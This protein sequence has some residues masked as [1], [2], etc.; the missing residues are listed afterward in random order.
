MNY[1][2]NIFYVKLALG[3]TIGQGNKFWP[4]VNQNFK[5]KETIVINDN[6]LD[7]TIKPYIKVSHAFSEGLVWEHL[8]EKEF[9]YKSLRTL[10]SKVKG[11]TIK[12]KGI[13]RILNLEHQYISQEYKSKIIDEINSKV[14]DRQ[15]PRTINLSFGVEVFTYI[16][17][18]VF[19]RLD[20]KVTTEAADDPFIELVDSVRKQTLK[21]FGIE[22]N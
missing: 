22:Q 8:T 19:S 16:P 21:L 17:F 15:K 18:D 3:D 13:K 2:N 10:Y 14:P 1:K 6:Q 12:P 5:S 11:Q 9:S 20:T 7:V 4:L